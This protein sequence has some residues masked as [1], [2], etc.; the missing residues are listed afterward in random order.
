MTTPFQLL[1]ELPE[2]VQVVV[3]G[4]EVPAAD[5]GSGGRAAAALEQTAAALARAVERID[6][7]IAALPDGVGAELYDRISGA[8][9]RL[10]EAT[11]GSGEF[12]RRL[13]ESTTQFNADTEKEVASM[14]AF[15]LMT[16]YQIMVAGGWHPIRAFQILSEARARHL[17][18]WAEFVAMRV[19]KGAAAAVERAGLLATQVG[20]FAAFAGGV[21][22]GIQAWQVGAGRRDGMDWES[23]A[24]A[25]VAGAG[26]AAGGALGAGLAMPA[27]P[28][29]Q[30]L[31]PGTASLLV[32]GSVI[33]VA[34]GLGGAIGGALGGYAM[35]GQFQLTWNEVGSNVLLGVAEAAAHARTRLETPGGLAASASDDLP[36]IPG[37]EELSSGLRVQ[38]PDP[39]VSGP[40]D[41][42]PGGLHGHQNGDHSP[43]GAGDSGYLAPAADG[44]DD[45]RALLQ[46][47]TEP[48][49]TSVPAQRRGEAAT[50]A[51]STAEEPS[52]V[53]AGSDAAT[54]G[55]R[56]VPVETRPSDAEPT[57]GGAPP[58]ATTPARGGDGATLSGSSAAVATPD[59]FGGRVHGGD[60]AATPDGSGGRARG[61]GPRGG[62][63][64]VA[65]DG[66][67]GRVRG[68]EGAVLPPK[69][70]GW[71]PRVGAGG[72][73]GATAAGSSGTEGAPN[74]G[75][76]TGV[77]EL[78]SAPQ[79]GSGR[80]IDGAS[81]HVSP[82]EGSTTT[83]G[84]SAREPAAGEANRIDPDQSAADGT[85]DPVADVRFAAADLAEKL[86][87][88]PVGNPD[89][90]A[91]LTPEQLARFQAAANDAVALH[92][93]RERELAAESWERRRHVMEHGDAVESLL[94]FL[95]AMRAGT[96][97]TPR[98]NQAMAFLLG[99]RGLMRQMG[100]G[101]GKSLVGAL[102]SLWQLSRGE[103]VELASGQSMRIHH[104]ITTT[105][106]L[107]NDG[108]RQFEQLVRSLGYDVARW[109]PQH[110]PGE[111]DRP[112]VYYMTYD[113]RATAQLHDQP[114]PG[115][116][117]TI[118]EADAVLAHN[119]TVHYLSDG[120]REE[121]SDVEAA[122]VNRVRKFLEVV[123]RSR[124]TNAPRLAERLEELGGRSFTAAERKAA[125]SVTSRSLRT[126]P[127]QCLE[128]VG[129]LWERHTGRTFTREETEM[130]RAFLD[131]KAGR[132]KLNRDFIVFDG[133]IQILDEYGKPRS[134]P[135]TNTDSRW[136]GGRHKMLEAMFEVD[137]YT[138]GTGLKQVTVEDVAA[139]YDRLLLMSGT[140]ERTAPEIKQNFPVQG[141]LAAVPDF[142]PSKRVAEPD[143]IFL[144]EAEKLKDAV[145]RVEQLRAEGRPVL[146]I[147]PFNDVAQKFSL[148]LD[149]AGVEHESIDGRWFAGHRDNNAAEEHLLEVK[150]GAGANHM[151][152]DKDGNPVLDKRRNPVLLGAVTVGTGM[153]GRGF[154]VSI[155]DDV[156]ALGGLH[157]HM[158]GRSPINPDEDHQWSSRPGRNG[159]NGSFCFNVAAGDDLYAKTHHH[160][161]Q[162]AVVHYRAAATAHAEAVAEQHA[163]RTA[164]TRDVPRS[165]PAEDA[166]AAK[167]AAAAADLAAAER[168][169]RSVTPWV[170]DEA[171][172]RAY[173]ERVMR[174]VSQGH[175]A[176][177]A[178]NA[179][180]ERRADRLVE[181][182]ASETVAP[183]TQPADPTQ[184]H[185][186]GAI[187][188]HQPRLSPGRDPEP[189]R[190]DSR[191]D[192]GPGSDARS[193]DA[194]HAPSDS[195]LEPPNVAGASGDRIAAQATAGGR[196]LVAEGGGESAPATGFEP[197]YAVREHD[198]GAPPIAPE[199]TPAHEGIETGEAQP[200]RAT[201]PMDNAVDS[202]RSVV[203]AQGGDLS[204]EG[205][206]TPDIAQPDWIDRMIADGR[207]ADPAASSLETPS[208]IDRLAD[209][210]DRGR[211]APS[212]RTT[213]KRGDTATP[214]VPTG[215]ADDR[216]SG[217]DDA[218]SAVP[219]SI[220]T[221]RR[222]R[223]PRLSNGP[224]GSAPTA[225]DDRAAVSVPGA[226]AITAD[227]S[228]PSPGTRRRSSG[229]RFA[230]VAGWLGIAA[231]AVAVLEAELGDNDEER[232]KGELNDLLVSAGLTP[233]AVA[234]LNDHL[235]NA[236]PVSLVEDTLLSD[237]RA[238][239]LLTQR[240]D[241]LLAA[242]TNNENHSDDKGDSGDRDDFEGAEGIRTV[243]RA[244]ARARGELAK[245]LGID[246]TEVTAE[247]A[248][249][250][251]SAALAR[252]ASSGTTH[253]ETGAVVAAASEY[254]ATTALRE[255]VVAMHRRTPHGCV[256]NGVTVRRVLY[257]ADNPALTDWMPD[258]TPLAGHDNSTVELASGG[259]SFRNFGN[260]DEVADSLADRP[261]GSA[262][263][264]TY[265]A[266]VD[267]AP[268]QADRL[269]ARRM[270]DHHHA[271]RRLGAAEHRS[272]AERVRDATR[273]ADLI[274]AL[275]GLP[276]VADQDAAPWIQGHLVTVYNNSTDRDR[277]NLVV[278]DIA[279]GPRRL[280]TT[281]ENL[282]S[283]TALLDT[284][285]DFATWKG[286]KQTQLDQ[287]NEPDRYVPALEFDGEGRALK[288]APEYQV[289]YALA[290]QRSADGIPEPSGH[291][292]PPDTSRP[293]SPAADS[294]VGV[295]GGPGGAS[296]GDDW[297]LTANAKLD[298]QALRGPYF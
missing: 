36:K 197:E 17:A 74:A 132:L 9:R 176:P 91:D 151:L 275:S 186:D 2:P 97:L 71:V 137:I 83:E 162:I 34:G 218:E 240:R 45:A 53:R 37:A 144:T 203:P 283:R 259:G 31:L 104:V 284:A 54:V 180:E 123:L 89:V 142:A 295:G 139:Q 263:V 127:D 46:E 1:A 288:C 59:T 247:T 106:T 155:T 85:S 41:S 141:G 168:E 228:A 269:Y 290:G 280:V 175:A 60:G 58:G 192:A 124:I 242:L 296:A 159:R 292:D 209:H 160:G 134:D 216:Q 166:A 153:L 262:W 119:A 253:P 33:A 204:D 76:T 115:K 182:S 77:A 150:D 22:A 279:A 140:L 201:A 258:Y 232:A 195:R 29:I 282:E 266:A 161:A 267:A 20:G 11:A 138:D 19:G 94:R 219:Q 95:D 148:M 212:R 42:R 133:K 44:G 156:D 260:L 78:V 227:A 51:G 131:V 16:V 206:R 270:L 248:R 236:P 208:I 178:D 75:S 126:Q 297:P 43:R 181:V 152:L 185:A 277:P 222:S 191:R 221:R 10:S 23:V 93:L 109:D 265:R 272:R 274:S 177:V 72:G 188:R 90:K 268:S 61:G 99:E 69:V 64:A 234:A 15:G 121:A 136:F 5:T 103:P 244:H 252:R 110:P 230:R 40:V 239:E 163:T 143:R 50:A 25:T 70:P 164:A 211:R 291:Q 117:A 55:D 65:P 128:T 220:S 73:D 213:P 231:Q 237:E 224:D 3:F 254:L 47:A 122:Q 202:D 86:A 113:E 108:L 184:S 173:L 194:L 145:R 7:E 27:L 251:L 199:T 271:A 200:T 8:A 49:A 116:T 35:T 174:R 257:G 233:A 26:A 12:C 63:G 87:D 66:S 13:A 255:V 293:V 157:A 169:L 57:P 48:V 154:D 167:V 214:V 189:N 130:A 82:V 96:G 111:P 81:A 276:R 289:Q 223:G 172:E 183:A 6:A 245:A 273:I 84:E 100:T 170:Q 298:V 246:S 187:D 226:P 287:L 28:R 14:A 30:R 120:Q 18:R 261:G 62:D 278:L 196:A 67:G 4:S 32:G 118:D 88:L 147:C 107:A 250:E 294:G 98:W 171:A 56:A 198:S 241:A 286:T 264:V 285:I 79:G 24:V 281:P 249:T 243:G 52:G 101:Q 190:D 229:H 158:L 129:A 215:S 217:R 39:T 92:R 80:P 179:A 210:A 125:R 238:L 207:T 135:K 38:P 21:D 193:T 146:V 68:G 225:A 112:T 256:N 205:G 102:D 105:E 165:A 149:K 114:P 235:D